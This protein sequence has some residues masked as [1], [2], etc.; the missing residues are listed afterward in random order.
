MLKKAKICIEADWDFYKG[1]NLKD[2][3]KLI[4]D[5]C[6]INLGEENKLLMYWF[7]HKKQ[8]TEK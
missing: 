3:K 8:K 2:V 5:K 6:Q 7:N 1:Q 4:A